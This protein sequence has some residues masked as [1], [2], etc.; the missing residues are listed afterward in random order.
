M[1]NVASLWPPPG[2][3]S[4]LTISGRPFYFQPPRP[5]QKATLG[6]FP[7]GRSVFTKSHVTS[8]RE[9]HQDSYTSRKASPQETQKDY[10]GHP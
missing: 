2:G 6:A 4:V 10:R 5:E 8:G 1:V 7:A 3:L 9:Q